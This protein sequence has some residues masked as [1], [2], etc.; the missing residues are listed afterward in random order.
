VLEKNDFEHVG[1]EMFF[2]DARGEE[3]A[4]VVMKLG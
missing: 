3:I 2:A 1:E 4:E